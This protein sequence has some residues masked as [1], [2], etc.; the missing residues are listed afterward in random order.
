MNVKTTKNAIF[1]SSVITERRFN[2]IVQ[3][4]LL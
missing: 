1:L 4:R 3:G 2:L